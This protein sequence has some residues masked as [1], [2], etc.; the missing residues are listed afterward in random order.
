M[1]P[2]SV[3]REVLAGILGADRAGFLSPR[4]AA[5]FAQCCA[6]VL[7]AEIRGERVCFEGHDTVLG[8]HPLGVDGA[9]LRTRAA[10]DD[11][12]SRAAT[13]REQVG[14]R[15]AI[16]RVDR[17][18]LSKNIIRGLEAYRELLR[19][20]PQWRNRVTHVALANPSR[21]DV[22]EYREYTG[23]VLRIGEEIRN[24]FSTAS[25]DPLVL[26]VG[27][28]YARSL[29]AYTLADVLLVN[30][31]RDG[32]NLVAKEAPVLSGDGLALILS[33]E[34]GAA[35]ELG[36]DSLLVNPFDV[37]E[38]ADALDVALRMPREQRRERTRRLAATATAL[39][40]QDWL[41]G[42]VDALR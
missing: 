14:G 3:A 11:V 6:D 12:V 32:M 2:A 26:D 7:D 22:A 1:L 42:Q 39:P 27:D 18:E 21:S 38:T 8:V 40:P 36:A 25:W 23:T 28:D 9:E 29:A 41:R 19:T 30:P 16:V 5:A 33:R 34:A 24:E 13:L 15:Q 17:M 4:W 20:R 35:D 31:I 10:Q 37:S